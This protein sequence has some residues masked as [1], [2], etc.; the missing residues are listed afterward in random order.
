LLTFP[1]I[2]GITICPTTAEAVPLN[3]E[4]RDAPTPPPSVAP[5]IETIWRTHLSKNPK[6]YDGPLLLTVG[7]LPALPSR[8]LLRSSYKLHLC[9]GSDELNSLGVQ[10]VIIGRDAAGIPHILLARRSSD[11]RMYPG[12][13]ENA[14]SGS[15]PPPPLPTDR[16]DQS[17]FINALLDEGVEE[18]GLDL[19]TA[20]IRL[21]ALQQDTAARSLDIMLRFDLADPIDPRTLP[22]PTSHN[23]WE[24]ADAAWLPI[25][26]IP[27]WSAQHAH[28]ISPPTLALFRWI[29]DAT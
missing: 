29:T 23:R 3:F 27:A 15:V 28:A 20:R 8:I 1:D 2:P 5:A 13:W 4:I 14:P 17:H 10:G 18:L 19:S 24:Y 12:L 7:T 22:C 6:L 11:V 26:E 9:L 16:I 25:A 21:V